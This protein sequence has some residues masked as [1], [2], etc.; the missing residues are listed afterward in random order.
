MRRLPL[1]HAVGLLVRR[2]GVPPLRVSERLRQRHAGDLPRGG[3]T[4][5][6]CGRIRRMHAMRRAAAPAVMAV[7][8]AA[9]AV[10]AHRRDELLQAARVAIEPGA[11]QIEI[12]L[13]PG[14]SLA[15]A[16]LTD[17][18][19]DRDGSLSTAE[20]GGYAATVLSALD[21]AVDGTAV[22][23]ALQGWSFP[24]ID[25]VRRG[26]G[27]IRV[28]SGA[29]LPPLAPGAHHLSM[30]NRHHPAQSVYLANAL[31]PRS[32]RVAVTAQHRDAEQRELVIDY[33]LRAAEAS[34]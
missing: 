11:V 15:N 34:S 28:Q 14:I 24:A 9:V 26:E 19:R 13:T 33:D 18:D 3:L 12:D 4:P 6:R 16:V 29:P 30:R 32:D 5:L 20:Q 7:L 21:V 22:P 31:V 25:V 23:M 8:V 10:S 2:P 27:V 17:I 1:R